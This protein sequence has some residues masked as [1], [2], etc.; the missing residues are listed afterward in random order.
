VV[1][2]QGGKMIGDFFKF[3]KG[4]KKPGIGLA[5]GG[6]SI[7]G[8]AHVGVL[9]VLE[10]HNIKVS[11]ISGTSSGSIVAALYAAGFS[12]A[13]IEEIAYQLDWLSILRPHFSLQGVFS[14]KRIQKIMEDYLPIKYFAETKIPLAIATVDILSSME[15]VFQQ[16]K[17]LIAFAVMASSSIPGLFS[18]VPYKNMLLMDGCLLNNLPVSLLKRYSPEYTV[19]VNVIPD[20]QI[21]TAPADVFSV[22]SRTNDIYQLCATNLAKKSAD[23]VL[24]PLHEYVSVLQAGKK[25]YAQLIRQGEK[26]AER[27]LIQLKRYV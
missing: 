19:A 9:K 1:Y 17:E 15:Y 10:K 5:L 8:V 2:Y 21:K 4:F 24:E 7:R 3:F 11:C 16:P 22:L 18:P 14:S 27:A 23:L 26:A 12:A 6:G 13:E 25:M 20:V